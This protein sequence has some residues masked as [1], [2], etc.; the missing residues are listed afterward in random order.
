M[1]ANY[2]N[3]LFWFLAGAVSSFL[4]NLLSEALF[5]SIRLKYRYWT[6]HRRSKNKKEEG[7]VPMRLTVGGFTVDYIVL[8]SERFT[9]ARIQCSYDERSLSLPVELERLKQ[10]FISDWKKDEA[11]GKTN[12]PYNS[13]TYGLKAFDVGYREIIDSEEIPVLRLI[14]S[15]TDYFTEKVTDLNFGNPVR[16]KYAAATDITVQPVPEFSSILGVTLNLITRDDYLIVTDRSLLVHSGAGKLHCSVAEHLL[17]PTDMGLN[18]A[19]DPFRCA[20]RGAQEELGVV[21]KPEKVEFTAF[22]VDPNLCQYTLVGW[23]QIEESSRDVK[24]LRSLAVPKDKWENRHLVFLRC[25]PN[26]IA[27]FVIR[28]KDRW[29][30]YGL[31]AVIFSLF[32]MGY[33][34]KEVDE[35]FKRAQS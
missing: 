29:V 26:S 20:L 27:N 19:P 28:N 6:L 4:I 12:L 30:S 18:R 2:M 13:P 21:L 5:P 9:Q 8:V 7:F 17:R 16:D 25:N 34:K 32:Q 11:S 23:S 22:G 10:Q 14:C 1:E 33:S 24:E 31:T 3:E 35:A 15:P